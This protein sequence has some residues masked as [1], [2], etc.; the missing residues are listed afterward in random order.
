MRRRCTRSVRLNRYGWGI[1]KNLKKGFELELRAAKQGELEAQFSVGVC[2][3]RGEGITVD[4]KEAFHWYLRAAKRGHPDAAHNVAHFYE[5]GRG[6]RK[7]KRKAHLWYA[8]AH[9]DGAG[10][11]GD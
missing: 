2:L 6:I 8:R 5:M 9:P 1:A 4:D 7:N 11:D 3:S 10:G